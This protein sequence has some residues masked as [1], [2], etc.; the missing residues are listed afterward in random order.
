MM[1][2][3]SKQLTTLVDEDLESAIRKRAAAERR[4]LSA[5][6]EQA[7]ITELARKGALPAGLE[8]VA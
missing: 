3:R 8:E 7:A 2:P 6:L 5:W 4:S 1:K